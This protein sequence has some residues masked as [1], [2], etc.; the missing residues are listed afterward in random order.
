V[1]TTDFTQPFVVHIFDIGTQLQK[2]L[3][4]ALFD[5]ALGYIVIRIIVRIVRRTMKFAHIQAGLR[6]VINSLLETT[7]WLFLMVQLLTDLGFSG[8][9]FFF[10][11]SI[12]ALGIAMA[13]GGSTLVSDIV[14]GIFLARDSD[15][16]VGDEVLA[17]E[18]PT[19]GVIERMD[20]R[21]TR[22]R[23]ADGV[24]HIIPNSVVE[25]KEWVLVHRRAEMSALT[26]AANVA[27]KLGQAA[28]GR[29]RNS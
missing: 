17:G 23:G 25:R 12:A 18:T 27:K 10:S 2:G 20:A 26:R 1:I 8:V 29:S 14:A 22:L 13:A 28:R 16:N 19:Q 3:P 5:V 7:L 9:I 6:G 15:F 4:A 11:G 21:R 24:L